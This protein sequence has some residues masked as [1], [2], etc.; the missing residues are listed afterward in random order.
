MLIFHIRLTDRGQETRIS[1]YCFIVSNLLY[2]KISIP[3]LVA[4]SFLVEINFGF[5]I[6]L[7]IDTTILLYYILDIEE[8]H[9]IQLQNYRPL[10]NTALT[11]VIRYIFSGQDARTTRVS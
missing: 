1:K 10:L 5:F 3:G 9:C 7:Y 4:G 8:F 2:N 11:G 6:R